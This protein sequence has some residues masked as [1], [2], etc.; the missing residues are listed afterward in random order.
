[1]FTT[2]LLVLLALASII[3]YAISFTLKNEEDDMRGGYITRGIKY[4]TYT[5]YTA[6]CL[7][8]L[9]AVLT[10]FATFTIVS[11]TEVGVP[12]AFGTVYDPIES[13]I[14]I[15]AP[16]KTVEKYPIRPVTVELS[17]NNVVLARTADAG[18]MR[19]EIAARWMVDK[20]KAQNLYMQVRTDDQN[21]I[22]EGI[23]LKNLRQAVGQVY[24]MTGNLDALNDRTKTTND[25]HNLLNEQLKVYGIIIEDVW[26]RSVEPDAKTAATISLYASQQQATRIAEEAK[27][28][29]AI[30]AERRIIEAAGLEKSAKALASMTSAQIQVLCMQVWQQVVT[31]AIDAG[32]N[33]YTNPCAAGASFIAK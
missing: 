27:K 9:T 6:L 32:V 23:V 7:F 12:V 21:S 2:A 28:T 30:E 3:A 22:S 5:R 24:S 4:K 10:F 1:M 13:G 14:H 8:I 25:I 15:L 20:A 19:V 33:I 26:L 29:A 11:A 17:G 31:K 18:Q 16:W